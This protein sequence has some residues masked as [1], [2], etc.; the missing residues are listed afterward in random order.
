MSKYTKAKKK[1]F[2][3]R[4]EV[5]TLYY[6]NKEILSYD[7]GMYEPSNW[8]LYTPH[9]FNSVAGIIHSY[10]WKGFFKAHKFA[11]E[12]K[13]YLLR[14]GLKDRSFTFTCTFEY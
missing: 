4:V 6:K 14:Y 1:F 13:D 3:K 10:E 2:R 12:N 11:V 8:Y 9:L 7:R 5:W